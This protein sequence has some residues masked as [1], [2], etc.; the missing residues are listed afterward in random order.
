[1]KQRRKTEKDK[2]SVFPT[3]RGHF[4]QPNR[5]YYSVLFPWRRRKRSTIELSPTPPKTPL[6]MPLVRVTGVD[7]DAFD[8]SD[9][10]KM[11]DRSHSRV[12]WHSRRSTTTTNNGSALKLLSHSDNTDETPSTDSSSIVSSVVHSDRD[13]G[14]GR[15]SFASVNS[16][17][18][19]TL[20]SAHPHNAISGGNN[21]NRSY[22]IIGSS[23]N[24]TF[25]NYY[26]DPRNPFDAQGIPEE[27]EDLSSSANNTTMEDS[28]LS[29][30]SSSHR[31][32]QHHHHHNQQ[33]LPIT[34][35]YRRT[36]SLRSQSTM[37]TS[38][39]QHASSQHQQRHPNVITSSFREEEEDDI[40]SIASSIQTS[41][42]RHHKDIT[43]AINAPSSVYSSQLVS[44]LE[45][46]VA[47]LNFELATTKSDLDQIQLENRKLHD[48]KLEWQKEVR[49]LKDE[50]NELR[51]TIEQMKRDKLMRTME[52]T[53]GVGRIRTSMDVGSCVVW[54]GSSVSGHTWVDEK[55]TTITTVKQELKHVE[56]LNVPFSKGENRHTY[57]QTFRSSRSSFASTGSYISED[58]MDKS[59]GSIG[60]V[61]LDNSCCSGANGLE[62]DENASDLRSSLQ[63]AMDMFGRLQDNLNKKVTTSALTSR[64]KNDDE[65]SAQSSHSTNESAADVVHDLYADKASHDEEEEEEYDDDDPFATWSENRERSSNKKKWFQRGDGQKEPQSQN[66]DAEEEEIARANN[67]EERI[68]EDPFDTAKGASTESEYTS[69]AEDG[70]LNYSSHIGEDIGPVS[71][72]QPRRGFRLPWQRGNDGR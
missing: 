15:H 11:N 62:S 38:S 34:T 70:N 50:N 33:Q 45:S 35:G 54:G 60:S 25:D 55:S 3:Q 18:S 14:G 67:I 5:R 8:V 17:V 57:K 63:S 29:C 30:A 39:K 65:P 6:T 64:N 24:S 41:S 31:G 72:Q 2:P 1:M 20:L 71:A 7:A 26:D 58:N 53:K 12:A 16:V 4:D 23:A 36:N 21:N 13:G 43:A 37:S 52:S 19:S 40:T 22:N 9:F 32:P 42:I 10:A 49:L 47:K 46:Q 51:L 48:E 61:N 59:I 28:S 69:F 56:K 27:E 44:Q 68:E 66:I